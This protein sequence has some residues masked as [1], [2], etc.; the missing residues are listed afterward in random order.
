MKFS[1]S[2]ETPEQ[3]TCYQSSTSARTTGQGLASSP[4]PD[5]DFCALWAFKQGEFD[6]GTHGEAGMALNQGPPD[7]GV[8][9]APVRIHLNNT[10]GIAHRYQADFKAA[11]RYF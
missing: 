3:D 1:F 11:S 2:I 4:F 9:P 7:Q 10:V 8:C 5:A 6:I